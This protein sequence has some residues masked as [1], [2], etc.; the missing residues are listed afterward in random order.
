MKRRIKFGRHRLR[1]G[2]ATRHSVSLGSTRRCRKEG[3]IILSH[4]INAKRFACSSRSAAFSF[5]ARELPLEL[6]L[7]EDHK[8]SAR[9]FLSFFFFKKNSALY[10]MRLVR[11]GGPCRSFSRTLAF[12][13][14]FIFPFLSRCCDVLY[15]RTCASASQPAIPFSCQLFSFRVRGRRCSVSTHKASSDSAIQDDGWSVCLR[16]SL[17]PRTWPR[18]CSVRMRGC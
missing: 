6:Y 3:F 5:W 8:T 14:F 7:S 11:T 12:F 15:E 13:H 1:G 10:V 4:F 16:R 2:Q 18:A 17:L 9:S